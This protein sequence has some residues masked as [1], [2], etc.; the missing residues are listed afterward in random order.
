V[1]AKADEIAP[2]RSMQI[3]PAPVTERGSLLGRA[4]DVG[5]E[6]CGEDAI[7][8]DGAREPVKNS[9]IASEISLALSPT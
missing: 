5:K 4:D 7:G 2:D 1:T 3:A 6:N 8:R 9:S